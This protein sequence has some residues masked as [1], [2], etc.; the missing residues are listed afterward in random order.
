MTIIA[1][2]HHAMDVAGVRIGGPRFHWL[3]GAPARVALDAV[4]LA[5]EA[6]AAADLATRT[7]AGDVETVM[8]FPVIATDHFDGWELRKDG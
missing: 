8:G 1:D 5:L 2:M 6:H 7:D 3:M 4:L